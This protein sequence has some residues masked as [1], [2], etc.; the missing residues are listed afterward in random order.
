MSSQTLEFVASVTV[1]ASDIKKI[2]KH[3]AMAEAKSDPLRNLLVTPLFAGKEALQ[4]VEELADSGRRVMFDSGGYYVQTGKIDYDYLFYPLLEI[5]RQNQWASIYVLPDDVPTSRDT[6][7]EVAYKVENTYRTSALFFHEMPDELK[8]RAMP[9]VHGHTQRQI[10]ACLETYLALG[11]KQI[12]FGSFG[13]MGGKQEVNIA[14]QSAIELARYVI[15]VAHMYGL[16]VHLFGLGVPAI[17][18]ML[19]GIG[20]DSFDSS[21]WLKAAG[22]GQV[23]LPLMRAYNIT[24]KSDKSELQQGIREDDFIQ[25]REF[26][27]H[28]CGLCRSIEN[29]RE[30]KMHRAVHNLITIAESV[31]IMNDFDLERIRRIYHRGSVRYRDEV[32]KWLT[33]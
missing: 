16:K 30:Y 10:D 9:V 11:V 24:Y 13:T 8:P 19:K 31:S 29:L 25:L 20:A 27:G 32:D 7:E 6:P 2:K 22:F 26:T 23:F 3:V 33:N 12:G 15:Q 1:C 14:S 28:E 17:T 18:A 4:L 21:S 5:Y